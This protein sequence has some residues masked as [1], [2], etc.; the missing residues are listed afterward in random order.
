MITGRL[1]MKYI[2]RE[3]KGTHFYIKKQTLFEIVKTLIL[4][5]MAFGIFFIGYYTLGTK[6]SLWS[7]IAVLALLP[8][9]KSLVG[10]IMFA[11]YR[12]IPDELYERVSESIGKLPALYEN[13][14]TTSEKSYYLPAIVYYKGSLIALL[15]SSIKET[16]KITQHLN[17]ILRNGGYKDISVKV[18]NKDLDFFE[19]CHK[20]N[21]LLADEISKSHNTDAIFTT[22]KAVSL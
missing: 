20:L 15:D 17:Y 14:L 2:T 11:R 6:K 16:D 22:I 12:S 10:V 1:L 13:I 7:V 8:A 4:F 18:Y 21:D 3:L 19:R 9:S 5:L